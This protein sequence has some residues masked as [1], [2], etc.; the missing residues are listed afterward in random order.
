MRAVLFAHE[1]L[2]H[3]FFELDH[4]GGCVMDLQIEMGGCVRFKRRRGVGGAGV[5]L[6]LPKVL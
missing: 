4:F 3:D 2:V 1:L 5:S 6:W